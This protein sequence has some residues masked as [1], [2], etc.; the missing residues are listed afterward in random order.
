MFILETHL[1]Q[2]QIMTIGKSLNIY[3]L[4][5][6]S[7]LATLA[8]LSIPPP[9]PHTPQSKWPKNGPQRLRQKQNYRGRRPVVGKKAT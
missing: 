3:N 9:L 6:H 7:Q 4:G 1:S 2:P 8:V 5:R